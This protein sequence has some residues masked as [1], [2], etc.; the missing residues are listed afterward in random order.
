MLNNKTYSKIKLKL[1][2]YLLEQRLIIYQRK[3]L[4]STIDK[5]LIKVTKDKRLKNT[6]DKRYKSGFMLQG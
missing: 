4:R 6:H 1:E 2:L 3:K 5:T